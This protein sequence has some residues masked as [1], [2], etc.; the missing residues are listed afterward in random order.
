MTARRTALGLHVL[1]LVFY[2][3]CFVLS[4]TH[5]WCTVRPQVF[6]GV[7][8]EFLRS[9]LCVVSRIASPDVTGVVGIVI[10]LSVMWLTVSRAP[11]G[12]II[13]VYVLIAVGYGAFEVL[14]REMWHRAL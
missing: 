8:P 3:H 5:E 9:I 2:V 6:E 4:I 14:F 12:V 11:I 7:E 1:A 13:R 10:A